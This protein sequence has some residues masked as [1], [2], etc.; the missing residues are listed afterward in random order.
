M[1]NKILFSLISIALNLVL[2][3]RIDGFQYSN[4][5]SN[6][7]SPKPGYQQIKEPD[8]PSTVVNSVLY[9]C[10][11]AGSLEKC[12][13]C[14]LCQ[15]GAICRQVL[16]ESSDDRNAMMGHDRFF[17]F[18]QQYVQL[19]AHS[20]PNAS[21]ELL[22]KLKSFYEFMCYCVPGYTHAYCQTDINECSFASCSNNSTCIDKVN[23]YEC[24]CPDGYTGNL[25]VFRKLFV[26]LLKFGVV[27]SKN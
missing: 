10:Y 15:N 12:N 7:I 14:E 19:S 13:I 27:R 25:F 6:D 2:I 16:K 8:L 20:H 1:R 22:A 24:K 11:N 9:K 4:L 17:M 21:M 26:G 5:K 3:S 23:R 18:S